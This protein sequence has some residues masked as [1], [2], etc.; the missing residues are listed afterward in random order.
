MTG[1]SVQAE[2]QGSS[3]SR[4]KFDEIVEHRAFEDGESSTQD[5][6]GIAVH[7]AVFGI[8]VFSKTR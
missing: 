5:G 8:L 3:R 1:L 4:G 6:T 7:S 2:R